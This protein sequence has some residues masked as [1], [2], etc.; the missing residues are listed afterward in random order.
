MSRK[1]RKQQKHRLKVKERK[2]KAEADRALAEQKKR[3]KHLSHDF[4]IIPTVEDLESGLRA[5]REPGIFP[6]EEEWNSVRTADL[7]KALR[8]YGSRV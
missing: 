5:L 7:R 6:T 2:R 4:D 8:N 1:T 3:D